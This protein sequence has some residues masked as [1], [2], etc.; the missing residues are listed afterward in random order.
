MLYHTVLSNYCR[1]KRAPNWAPVQ[2]PE[3][4]GKGI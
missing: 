3:V 4:R 2:G 1:G